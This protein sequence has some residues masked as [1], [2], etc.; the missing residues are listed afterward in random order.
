MDIQIPA[1]L[2]WLA[3]LLI[4]PVGSENEWWRKA[5]ELRA[6][7]ATLRATIPDLQR[8]RAAN[9]GAWTGQAAGTLDQQLAKLLEGD[10]SV[11]KQVAAIETLA[12]SA[13]SMGSKVVSAKVD[14]ISNLIITAAFIVWA[15]ANAPVTAG[16]SEAEIPIAEAAAEAASKEIAATAEAEVA[17]ELAETAGRTMLG[18]LLVKGLVAAGI[19][20]GIGAGQQVITDVVLAAE[21]H[22]EPF[23]QALGELLLSALSMGVAGAVGGL[24]G[25]V[26][27]AV[28]KDFLAPEVNRIARMLTQ[29]LI[30]VS[31]AEAA[32][33][34]GT[35]VGGGNVTTETL[36]GGL[37]GLSDA[38][39]PAHGASASDDTKSATPAS[40]D[41]P[42]AADEA[43]A[44]AA[45]AGT[46]SD[47]AGPAAAN[48]STPA[49]DEGAP[50]AAATAAVAGDG[51]VAPAGPSPA[52][53][54]VAGRGVGSVNGTPPVEAERSAAG[55]VSA[56]AGSA[57]G[58]ARVI[59]DS[60]QGGVDRSGGVPAAG[61][62]PVGDGA[63]SPASDLAPS[64][65]DPQSAVPRAPAAGAGSGPAG[66]VHGADP[67]L[68]SAA[69]DSRSG[70]AES[71][72]GQSAADRAVLPVAG[73]SDSVAVAA[74]G[75]GHAGVEPGAGGQVAGT[76]EG[77]GQPVS[78]QRGGLRLVVASRADDLGAGKDT[79][80]P[81]GGQPARSRLAAGRAGETTAAKR[82]GLRLLPGGRADDNGAGTDRAGA[83][84]GQLALVMATHADEVAPDSTRPYDPLAAAKDIGL[85]AGREEVGAG[86]PGGGSHAGTGTEE[87]TTPLKNCVLASAD[88]LSQRYPEREF[89]VDTEPDAEGKVPAEALF[90]AANCASEDHFVSY[91]D[92]ED[93]LLEKEPDGIT[94]KMRDGSAA[95]VASKW[96][97]GG[98]R[99]GGHVFL[100]VKD[101][102]KVYYVDRKTGERGPWP[103][104]WGEDQVELTAVGYL[105]EH[106]EPLHRLDETPTG[107]AAADK[108]GPAQGRPDDPDTSPP[109][110][111]EEHHGDGED[112]HELAADNEID[113]ALGRSGDGQNAVDRV[114]A[115]KVLDERVPAVSAEKVANV[116][117]DAERSA[118]RA[119]DN[120]RWM[121]GLP[122][123]D[124]ATRT[125]V[126]ALI[127]AHPREMGNAWG[128]PEKISDEAT[129]LALQRA[130]DRAD[131]LRSKVDDGERL[132]RK[133]RKLLKFLE[134]VDRAKPGLHEVDHAVEQAGFDRPRW[135]ALDP[136]VFRRSGRA[137][138][139]IGDDPYRPETKISFY[140]ARQRIDKLGESML[141][142]ALDQ[143]RLDKQG[144]PAAAIVWVGTNTLLGTAFHKAFYSDHVALRAAREAWAEAE[145]TEPRGDNRV[146]SLRPLTEADRTAQ[147]NGLRQ[148]P[149]SDPLLFAHR[150]AKDLLPENT[151]AAFELGLEHRATALELDVHQTKD[152]HLVVLHDPWINR[153]SDG[154]GF[155][156]SKTL[157]ELK[158]FD[159]G[160]KHHSAK[161]ADSQGDTQIQTLGEVL[162]R[163]NQYVG[164]NDRPVTVFIEM[165]HLPNFEFVRKMAALLDSKHLI[166]PA[167]TDQLR[168]VVTSSSP[169]DMALAHRYA[170]DLPT[171]LLA[172]QLPSMLAVKGYLALAEKT[173]ANG[174][175][176]YNALT[177][178][179]DAVDLAHRKG[180]SVW[181]G[182]VHDPIE[183]R[184]LADLGVDIIGS[185]NPGLTSSWL[186]FA[187]ADPVVEQ[188]VPAMPVT[189][190]V[191]PLGDVE[192][193]TARARANGAWMAGLSPDDSEHNRAIDALVQSHPHQIGNSWGI[194][195]ESVDKANRLVIQQ[196]QDRADEMR[197]GRLNAAQR[198][199]VERPGQIAAG[200]DQVDGAAEQAGL[201]PSRILA[202]DP[203]AFRGHGHAVIVIGDD[204]Y[205]PETKVSWHRPTQP[206]ERVGEIDL[207][208]VLGQLRSDKRQGPAAAMI[209]IGKNSGLPLDSPRNAFYSDHAAF[210]A[211]REAWAEAADTEDRSD[212]PRPPSTSEPTGNGSIPA[213]PLFRQRDHPLV[214][215]HRGGPDDRPEQTLAAY[216]EAERQ[217]ANAFEG[218]AQL[219][220]DGH[221]VLQHAPWVDHTSDGSGRIDKMTLAELRELDFGVHHP[222]RAL[223]EAQGDTSI[224]TV[225]R[226]LQFVGEHDRPLTAVV[227]T[228][229]WIPGRNYFDLE[230]KLVELLQ[231]HGFASPAPGEQ[232][233][234]VVLSFYPESLKLIRRLAPDLPTVYHAPRLEKL[235]WT[236]VAASH[237]VAKAIGANGIDHYIETLRAYPQAVDLAARQGLVVW[238]RAKNEQDAQYAKDLG[239]SWIGTDHPARTLT[240]LGRG[241]AE[242]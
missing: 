21:G 189:K 18:Q 216:Q 52:A 78:G 57:A 29:A 62:G 107:T 71:A 157:A 114:L 7:A 96:V 121:A 30:G 125:L 236:A 44:P 120:A 61:V 6:Q 127:R 119:R 31:S 32:N 146:Y 13:D 211:A 75:A 54:E 9:Q 98:P 163:V 200:L 172:P 136:N 87:S 129:R 84:S 34:A 19:G 79:S 162:D 81:G 132:T 110:D 85:A 177:A 242:G 43:R 99:E 80:R 126:D 28:F 24:F 178:F 203:R 94:D 224:M 123:D 164:D 167:P 23:A 185:N 170:P 151:W 201:G 215:A 229:H 49:K 70:L 14:N 26:L 210:T 17:A 92:I 109:G 223:G 48:A 118:A 3:H 97:E 212:E 130:W 142:S 41:A 59:P 37:F 195:T 143:L 156:R 187:P 221:L 240:W 149:G 73:V 237:R 90:K 147:A 227:E 10:N 206:I 103:P 191:N 158:A 137:A 22:A 39:G 27:G 213:N 66:S 89:V 133:E 4:W 56:G 60:P 82:D 134:V 83:G 111:G 183:A 150:G 155:V 161:L 209:W 153:T 88:E 140:R 51:G 217:G 135:V 192:L 145:G 124:P 169:L 184:Y 15:H 160:A 208:P 108:I 144:G 113:E 173:H 228:K 165:K 46:A 218:D 74:A 47:A 231:R 226:L 65:G 180:L 38:L 176:L 197:S 220:R 95:I 36:V 179:P 139:V 40:V 166:H 181:A 50:Q 238:A 58:N 112:P 67:G 198:T 171:V 128:V 20:A 219:T 182:V 53:S 131:E 72:G 12:D 76:G 68:P 193:A 45:Q 174:V 235:P 175:S 122:L 102:G 225:D 63:K 186:G 138:L 93:K 106:G 42:G 194:R 241:P 64:A 154:A 214:V 232:P 196:A 33:I 11:D 117:G 91:S 100:A 8:L 234:A 202:L 152:G 2:L 116:F 239:V 148:D 141:G 204:P 222:S 233:P 168:A 77:V 86:D 16:A 115:N 159:F 190:W 199:E 69:R 207:D 25:Q 105:D 101:D 230:R 104:P 5:G 35:L 188:R 1:A 205:H 55:R